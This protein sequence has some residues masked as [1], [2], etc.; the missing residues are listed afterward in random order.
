MRIL[1]LVQEGK[2]TPEEGAKLLES[3]GS[4]AEERTPGGNKW[5]RIQI[6]D[7]RGDQVNL[8]L[9]I[10]LLRLVSRFVPEGAINIGGRPLPYDELVRMV[11]AGEGEIVHIADHRGDQ[12]VIRVE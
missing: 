10:H 9:P 8:R 11:E 3:L 1:R 7:H 6:A 4:G 2:V 5:V 12:V